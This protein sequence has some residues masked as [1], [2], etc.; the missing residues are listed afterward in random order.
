MQ[1]NT[2]MID[3]TLEK[4][5]QQINVKFAD[6]C[7]RIVS[8]VF[9]S[10]APREIDDNAGQCFIKRHIGMAITDDTAFVT[11]GP[12]Y[13]LSQRY[14]DIFNSV[15]GI[16]MQIALGEDL[17][18]DKTMTPNLI[19]HVLKKGHACFQLA[20]ACAIEVYRYLDPGFVGIALNLRHA[21]AHC[22]S[23]MD[24]II[25]TGAVDYDNSSTV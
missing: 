4:F 2:G 17:N 15:V 13:S 6:H 23:P 18:I 24:K 3:E 1:G 14:T 20:D 21:L 9:E 12:G 11:N 25:I 7:P 10:R 16:D 8:M 22:L 19:K 5:V